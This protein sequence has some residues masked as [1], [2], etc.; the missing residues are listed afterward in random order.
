MS[1]V[2][3]MRWKEQL[4]DA[5]ERLRQRGLADAGDVFDQQV[6]AREQRDQRELDDVFLALDDVRD[7]ALKL[8][9]AGAGGS[10]RGLQ[11]AEPSATKSELL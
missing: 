6:A 10:R 7:R 2:N 1:E 8:G 9:E 5:R 3:W 4:N 11:F